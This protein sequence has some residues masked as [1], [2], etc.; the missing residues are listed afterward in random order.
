MAEIFTFPGSSETK[1][2][3]A[4]MTIADA[5]PGLTR[6]E[7]LYGPHRSREAVRRDIEAHVSARKAY[8]QEVAWLA[9]AEAEGLP[10]ANIEA[11]RQE[12]AALPGNAGCRAAPVDLHAH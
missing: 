8:S 1:A 9:A 12:T 4:T 7:R 11:A 3:T 10:A 5:G 2:T 6:G